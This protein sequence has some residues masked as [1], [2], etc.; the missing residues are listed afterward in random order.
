MRIFA[1]A[2]LPLSALVASGFTDD[3]GVV[4]EDASKTVLLKCPPGTR[5][6]FAIPDGVVKVDAY[7]FEMCKRLT[8]LSVPASVEQLDLGKSNQFALTALA[9]FDVNP[10]NKYY[11]SRDGVLF[12]KIHSMLLRCP[13]KKSGHYA[14]PRGVIDIFLKAFTGC[15]GLTSISFPEGISTIHASAFEGC[16]GLKRLDLPR[17]LYEI[18]E[19]AFSGCTGLKELVIPERVVQIEKEAFSG[20]TGLETVTISEGIVYIGKNAFAGCQNLKHLQIPQDFHEDLESLGFPA[21][22]AA[23]I[24][25]GSN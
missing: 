13:P 14:I 5:G 4:Y 23:K 6:H 22:L 1:W 9:S 12:D 20:C 18:H 24:R 7:A 17:S 21:A 15:S 2:L 8:S 19:S 25:S 10:A 11:S 16:T 3:G